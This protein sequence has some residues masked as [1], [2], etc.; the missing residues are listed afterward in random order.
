MINYIDK[1][2]N[3]HRKTCIAL[4]AHFP[5]Y[6]YVDHIITD[7]LNKIA[8]QV[9]EV[10]LKSNLSNKLFIYFSGRHILS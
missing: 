3:F 6:L 5:V 10:F 9:T 2:D 4:G 7:V 1:K 8:L